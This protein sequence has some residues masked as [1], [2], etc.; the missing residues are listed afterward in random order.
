MAHKVGSFETF[1]NDMGIFDGVNPYILVVMTNE[2]GGEANAL[3]YISQV[4][5]LVWNATQEHFEQ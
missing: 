5:D 1:F 2:M 4:S 3:H